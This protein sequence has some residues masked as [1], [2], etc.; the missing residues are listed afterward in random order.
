MKGNYDEVE[1]S[2]KDG[3]LKSLYTER[4]GAEFYKKNK[5]SEAQNKVRSIEKDRFNYPSAQNLLAFIY[6]KMGEKDKALS[7][8]A[9]LKN[10]YPNTYFGRLGELKL[11]EAKND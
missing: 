2:I 11:K 4:I 5:L 10:D 9:T 1:K 7:I 3:E 8:W 6:E